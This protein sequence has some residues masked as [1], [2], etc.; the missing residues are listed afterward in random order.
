MRLCAK[1]FRLVS[2]R[3]EMI[4]EHKVESNKKELVVKYQLALKYGVDGLL[5]KKNISKKIK[6]LQ[7]LA[8]EGYAPA[9]NDLADCY[10]KGIGVKNDYGEA[11]RLYRLAAEKG[12]ARAQDNLGGCYCYGMGV[13][14]DHKEAVRLFQLAADQG[15]APAQNNLGKCYD[16]GDGVEKNPKEA[17]RFYRLAA[18]QD[19]APA[20]FKLGTLYHDGEG[21]KKNLKEALHLYQLASAQGEAGAQN[22]LGEFYEKGMGV[23]QDIDKAISLYKSAA[24]EGNPNAQINLARCYSVGLGNLNQDEIKSV[25]LYRFAA[26]QG[27]N[28]AKLDLASYYLDHW[29][30][31][32]DSNKKEEAIHLIRSIDNQEHPYVKR[33]LGLYH[34]SEQDYLLA[35]KLFREAIT[36]G[37][38]EAKHRLW[39]FE[40]QKRLRQEECRLSILNEKFPTNENVKLIEDIRE[41][42]EYIKKLE[43]KSGRRGAYV[44]DGSGQ[45]NYD[46]ADWVIQQIR[47]DSTHFRENLPIIV[48]F[49]AFI[50]TDCLAIIASYMTTDTPQPKSTYVEPVKEPQSQCLMM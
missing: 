28:Q 25:W 23:K 13:E 26:K 46:G 3:I 7:S 9:Q 34:A 47:R 41:N 42:L 48:T 21:I 17:L 15:Y 1:A 6:L 33:T 8:E 50:P 12:Y 11:L 19:H 36:K 5:R 30:R 22:S 44:G 2:W 35:A 16:R 43:I 18:A 38:G 14:Q 4:D 24:Q 31:E 29:E 37:D 39:D 27:G 10:W 20:Q 40:F 49:I 45:Y 32:I